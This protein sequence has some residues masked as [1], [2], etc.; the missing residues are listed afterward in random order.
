MQNDLFTLEET[1]C[2]SYL[3]VPSAVYKQVEILCAQA[4][5]FSTSTSRYPRRCH[6]GSI[7]Q[8]DLLN[9]VYPFDHCTQ[10]TP[11]TLLSFSWQLPLHP[12]A[13]DSVTQAGIAHSECLLG[14][15]NST[16]WT[17]KRFSASGKPI[18][19]S[20]PVMPAWDNQPHYGKKY[21]VRQ[22]FI[23]GHCLSS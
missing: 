13:P 19:L 21:R 20:D 5:L 6:D 9:A 10:T 23:Y 14:A 1:G 12:V 18:T 17:H 3:I 2:A 7:D 8:H 4:F 15:D 16:V 22:Y 11:L